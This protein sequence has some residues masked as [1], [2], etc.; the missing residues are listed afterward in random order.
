MLKDEEE[1][2]IWKAIHINGKGGDLKP[3]EI[4]LLEECTSIMELLL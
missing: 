1:Y 3:H 4:S 2:L